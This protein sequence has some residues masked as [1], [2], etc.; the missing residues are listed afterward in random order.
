MNNT[1]IIES[2]KKMESKINNI[3]GSAF[4]YD[5]CH[6]IYICETNEEIQEMKEFGYEIKEMNE[7]L[8][9]FIE[10]CELK[11]IYKANLKD[12]KH[13]IIAQGE[14]DSTI[15][16]YINNGLYVDY[17]IEGFEF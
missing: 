4:A 1:Q 9:T 17:E 3:Q 8:I 14:Y 11:F 6:K 2:I 10:S 5:G 13:Q 16:E 7:L 12:G 15:D